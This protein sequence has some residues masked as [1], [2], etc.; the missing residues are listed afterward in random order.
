MTTAIDGLSFTVERGELF[1][2]LGPNGAGKS[3]LINTLCTL[4]VPTE[5]TARVNGYD[6]TDETSAVR[7]SLGIVF[8]EPALDGAHRRGE[9]GVSRTYVR[10]AK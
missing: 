5:G 4:L 2:L 8:Q 10:S 1:G 6:I 3:T 9:P 7:D